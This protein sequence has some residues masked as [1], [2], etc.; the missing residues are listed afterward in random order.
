MSNHVSE[1]FRMMAV[2]AHPDDE[3]LGI[4]RNAGALCRRRRRDLSADRYARRERP[5]WAHP[6]ALRRC[7]SDEFVRR[8][9]WLPPNVLGLSE[10]QFLDYMDGAVDQCAS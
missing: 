4:W 1:P 7:N 5:A 8:S 3:S 6:A 10:V 9:C 2:L